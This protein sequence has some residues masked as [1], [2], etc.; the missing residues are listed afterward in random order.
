MAESESMVD[1]TRSDAQLIIGGVGSGKSS[2]MEVLAETYRYHKS[3]IF[4][5]MGAIDGEGMWWGIAGHPKCNYGC[6]RCVRY[7]PHSLKKQ[8][9]TKHYSGV[10]YSFDPEPGYNCHP[11]IL[12]HP[13]YYEVKMPNHSLYDHIIPYQFPDHPTVGD[14][15][16]LLKVGIQEDAVISLAD[17]LFQIKPHAHLFKLMSQILW[18]IGEIN[19]ERFQKDFTLLAREIGSIIFARIRVFP[20]HERDLKRSFIYVTRFM[21]HKGIRFLWDLQRANDLDISLRLHASNIY[22]KKQSKRML[23]EQFRTYWNGVEFR[24]RIMYKNQD[25]AVINRFFPSIGRLARSRSYVLKEDGKVNPAIDTR[26]AA[27]HHRKPHDDFTLWTGIKLEKTGN[28][29]PKTNG[30]DKRLTQVED[31]FGTLAKEL[32]YVQGYPKRRVLKILN[33]SGAGMDP[34]TLNKHLADN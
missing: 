11:M 21:R 9:K 7:C 8:I 27:F 17:S 20:D 34:R 3:N 31:Q 5:L 28:Y 18:S 29:E 25:R 15:E 4:D 24:R 32:H 2:L 23:G 26:M 30:K 10:K 13:E 19:Q 6:K 22:I 16:E 14:I 1:P 12:V 33:D